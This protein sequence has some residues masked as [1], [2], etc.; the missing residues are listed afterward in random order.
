[1]ARGLRRRGQ[2]A[3]DS[4]ARELKPLGRERKMA[5]ELGREEAPAME[6]G[7]KTRAHRRCVGAQGGWRDTGN[8]SCGARHWQGP[9]K[10]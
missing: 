10:S 7:T 1:M 4:T 2:Q 6:L 5:G 9:R 8:L 3:G